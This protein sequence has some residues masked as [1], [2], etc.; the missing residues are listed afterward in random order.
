MDLNDIENDNL[1]F[2]NKDLEF[3]VGAFVRTKQGEAGQITELYNN[4]AKINNKFWFEL[5]DLTLIDIEENKIELSEEDKKIKK[6]IGNDLFQNLKTLKDYYQNTKRE[7]EEIRKSGEDK[8]EE[9]DERMLIL[10]NIR[11]YIEGFVG[12]KF[13]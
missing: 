2:N 5:S 4:A 9:C 7:I 12:K 6:V 11:S 3:I 8:H 1:E 10:V 13:N